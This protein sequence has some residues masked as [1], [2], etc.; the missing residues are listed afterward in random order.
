MSFDRWGAAWCG[1]YGNTFVNTPAL[2]RLASQ[3]LLVEWMIAQSPDL[4]AAYASYWRGGDGS[5]QS[6]AARAREAGWDTTLVTDEAE[7]A[8]IGAASDFSECSLT[9][10]AVLDQQTLDQ[11][12]RSVAQTRTADLLAVA[13]EKLTGRASPQLLWVHSQGMQGPWDAPWKERLQFVEHEDDPQPSRSSTPPQRNLSLDA[14]PDIAFG[15][16]QCYAAQVQAIDQCLEVMFQGILESGSPAQQPWVIVTSPRGYP[17][18]EHLRIGPCD[19]ALYGE[20]LHVPLLVRPPGGL[21]IA[22][23]YPAILQP[24]DLGRWLSWLVQYESATAR[25]VDQVADAA[26]DQDQAAAAALQELTQL[27]RP[28]AVA[29]HGRQVAMR[30][31]AWHALQDAD[32]VFE[33][34]VK[35]D[36]RWEANEIGQRCPEEA[37]KLRQALRQVQAE[38]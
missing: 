15:A 20:L 34:Y 26:Q 31:A 29:R 3:S 17:L 6:L 2:N 10:E 35:P 23:R 21:T 5:P 38:R 33:L 18:G 8:G 24:D 16:M 37:E 22:R 27:A 7:L 4:N 1:P 19:E 14:D 30:T 25:D 12:A 28:S 9:S 11:L 36:D 32:D 13:A